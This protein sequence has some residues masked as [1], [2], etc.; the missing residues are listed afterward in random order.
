MSASHHHELN[1]CLSLYFLLFYWFLR[2]SALCSVDLQTSE[3]V[4]SAVGI[5]TRIRVAGLFIFVPNEVRFLIVI[6]TVSMDTLH[7]D[8][9]SHPV[10]NV[11][12]WAA[13]SPVCH[14]LINSE[15]P[16]SI[17]L[18]PP[19]LAACMKLKALRHQ[20]KFTSQRP[21]SAGHNLLHQ[22][23]QYETTQ[24]STTWCTNHQLMPVVTR[25][26]GTE[27]QLPP[28]KNTSSPYL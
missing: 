24:A 27:R 10:L 2:L 28:G 22:V 13:S 12:L 5:T 18:P 25:K 3:L 21:S 7:L 19:P 1:L 9:R 4:L 15:L 14:S 8:T 26:G 17:P 11:L 20:H 16:S 23:G 6:A